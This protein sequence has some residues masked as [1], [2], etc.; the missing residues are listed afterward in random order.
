MDS[1]KTDRPEKSYRQQGIDRIEE[2]R[3]RQNEKWGVQNHDMMTWLAILHE[4][5]GELAQACLHNKFGGPAEGDIM[6]EAVQVAA[7]GLQIVEFLL[8]QEDIERAKRRE[9]RENK[10]KRWDEAI[11]FVDAREEAK[12]TRFADWCQKVQDDEVESSV[13]GIIW[14]IQENSKKWEP[15]DYPINT[16]RGLGEIGGG[17][18]QVGRKIREKLIGKTYRKNWEFLKKNIF[19]DMATPPTPLPPAPLTKS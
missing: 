10:R 7:V 13:Y 11:A 2:E 19:G 6:K 18:E 15:G 5:T 12:D 17:P 3:N 4:E 16:S 9:E 1:D 8:E 14:D